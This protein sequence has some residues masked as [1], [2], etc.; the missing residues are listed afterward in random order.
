MSK[1]LVTKTAL[2][3]LTGMNVYGQSLSSGNLADLAR[4]PEEWSMVVDEW[5]DV[6]GEQVA[7]M[8]EEVFQ[9]YPDRTVTLQEEDRV[10]FADGGRPRFLRRLNGMFTAPADG[11]YRFSVCATHSARMWI[12]LDGERKQILDLTEPTPEEDWDHSP[13][14]RSTPV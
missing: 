3:L 9:T 10:L 1:H 5:H 7:E 4:N 11:E 2:L 13:G 6:P 8:R 12:H 14:Q